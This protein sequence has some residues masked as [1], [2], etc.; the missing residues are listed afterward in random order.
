[1]SR[2]TQLEFVADPA[3]RFFESRGIALADAEWQEFCELARDEMDRAMERLQRQHR[4]EPVALPTSVASPS[5]A[6]ASRPKVSIKGLVDVW[7]KVRS[8]TKSRSLKKYTHRLRE[9]SEYLSHDDALA[10]TS[11]DLRGW[12][13]HLKQQGRSAKTINDDCVGVVLTVFRAAA[14]E[15]VIPAYPFTS[16]GFTLKEESGKPKRRPYSNEEA[17][18]VLNASRKEK[19]AALRW[20]PWIMAYTGA[21]VG[22]VAQLRPEDV[23]A[24]GQIPYLAITD[25]GDEQSTKNESSVR[26]VPLH[27]ALRDEG[28]LKFVAKAPRGGFLFPDLSGK[29][30]EQRADSGSRVYMRWLRKTVGIKDPRIVAHSWRHRMEDELREVDAPDEVAHAI[31]GRT[32]QGSRALYG[33][34]VSLRKKAEWL[35]KVPAVRMAGARRASA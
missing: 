30:Q 21:R 8:A 15:E 11:K 23:K 18:G 16:G 27:P 13:D 3:K 20:M 22:E 4:G 6:P 35:A 32:S 10:V 29:T 12:R 2:A 1:V 26:D 14:R 9:F 7:A 25:Q 17:A 19:S 24:R 28:F 34:G 5:T 33:H 31:T